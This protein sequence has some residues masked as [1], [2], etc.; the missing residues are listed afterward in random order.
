[1][2]RNKILAALLV[3]LLVYSGFATWKWQKAEKSKEKTLSYLEGTANRAAMCLEESGVV[4]YLLDKNASDETL[5]GYSRLFEECAYVLETTEFELFALTKDPRHY[6]LHVFG[7]TLETLF[8]KARLDPIN[9]PKP[10]LLKNKDRIASISRTLE[11]LIVKRT[12][13]WNLTPEDAKKLRA[14]AEE[15]EY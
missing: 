1:M 15:I 2:R 14:M 11:D 5:R 10:I 3:V 7:A 12:G 8:N 4:S 6:D 9:G 13:L